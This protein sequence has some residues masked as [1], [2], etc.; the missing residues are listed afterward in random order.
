MNTDE[1]IRRRQAHA[2]NPRKDALH[3]F[4]FCV[5][6]VLLLC[7]GYIISLNFTP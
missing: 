6:I 5:C 7:V 2:K 1:Y 3:G 4:L